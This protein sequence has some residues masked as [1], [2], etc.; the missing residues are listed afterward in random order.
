MDIVIGFNVVIWDFNKKDF[1]TIN[2]IPYFIDKYDEAKNKPHSF[3]E[4]MKFVEDE[5]LYQFWSRC[6]YEMLIADLMETDI[7]NA[8][9]V[10]VYNQIKL[11]LDVVTSILIQ[12]I[13]ERNDSNNNICKDK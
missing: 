12:A 7:N 11:N 8:K 1:T 4:F 5:A 3:P 6:E 9:K 10:D 2:V 13:H